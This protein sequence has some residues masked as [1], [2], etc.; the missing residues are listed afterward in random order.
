[1]RSRPSPQGRGAATPKSTQIFDV[2]HLIV[3]RSTAAKPNEV[4]II[5]MPSFV[6]QGI[7]KLTCV[8]ERGYLAGQPGNSPPNMTPIFNK[9]G[10]I[11]ETS[12]SRKRL[13]RITTNLNFV[14]AGYC[15]YKM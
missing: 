14:I 3:W 5:F 8:T 12:I 2:F 15:G 4:E 9:I 11:A 1:V 6:R 13:V 10:T 7:P